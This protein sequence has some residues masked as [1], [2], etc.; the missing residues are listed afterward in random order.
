MQPEDTPALVEAAAFHDGIVIAY[1]FEDIVARVMRPM[2]WHVEPNWTEESSSRCKKTANFS[3]LREFY[4]GCL[5]PPALAAQ[6]RNQ[7]VHFF[8]F[9]PLKVSQKKL[10][11]SI[12]RYENCLITRTSANIAINSIKEATQ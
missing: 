7:L 4:V 6:T 2:L 12:R 5:T 8:D 11:C 1:L 3:I 9:Y 10:F